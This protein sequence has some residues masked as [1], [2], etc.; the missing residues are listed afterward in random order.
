MCRSSLLAFL[1]LF[2]ETPLFA[3]PSWEL[4]KD[5]DNI[6]VFVK[7]VEG[8]SHHAFRGK[9]TLQTTINTIVAAITDVKS[10]PSWMPNTI[11]TRVLES[12]EGKVSIYYLA[13]DA[14]WP[15]KDR[16][17]IYQFTYHQEEATEKTTI[18]VKCL[19]DYL[20]E[21]EGRLRIRKSEGFWLLEPLSSDSVAVTYELY[22]EP[23]GSVP[24]WLVNSSAVN[25]P[26][27][28][29]QSLRRRVELGEYQNNTFGFQRN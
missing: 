12:K 26:F 16:D 2:S 18:G 1:L 17:G 27:K 13:A 7:K 23:G 24:A 29:L 25:Q 6:Q 4:K 22:T 15:V 28:T 3:Q 11:E 8:S 9:M 19:P 14:P 10:F 20:P 5:E 21:K